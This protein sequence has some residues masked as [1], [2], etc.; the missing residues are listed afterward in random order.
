MIR[1]FPKSTKRMDDETIAEDFNEDF[2]E[3]FH[4]LFVF[5]G[6]STVGKIHSLQLINAI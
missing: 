6:Q 3:D 5:I 2:N 4:R 1:Q